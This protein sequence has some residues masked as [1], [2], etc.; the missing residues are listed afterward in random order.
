MGIF[1][2]K[3]QKIGCFWPKKGQ[4]IIFAK[5][6]NRQILSFLEVQLHAGKQINLYRGF[7]CRT[8]THG[9]THGSEFIG[10][11]RK[12]QDLRGTKKGFQS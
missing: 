9:R 2:K 3:M 4:F 12:S 11:F 1:G 6:E 5:N 8:G 7:G 10:S